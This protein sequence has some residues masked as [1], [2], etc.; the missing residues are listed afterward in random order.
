MLVGMRWCKLLGLNLAFI[1]LLAGVA[2]AAAP[3]DEGYRDMYSRDFASAHTRFAAWMADHPDDPL[4]PASDA[5]AYMFPEFDRLQIIDVQLFGEPDP[6]AGKARPAPDVAVRAHFDQRTQQAE[7]LADA[8]LAKSPKDAPA[9]FVKML[10]YGLRADY[11]EMI[12]RSDLKALKFS[13][14][15]A[16]YSDQT[17]AADPQMYDAHIATGFENYMLSLKP[18]PVRWIIHIMGGQ[19]DKAKGIA[20]L[21][22]TAAKGRY[23]APFA[24]ILLAVAELRDGNKDEAK[25]I[26]TEL[27]TQYPRNPMYAHQLGRIH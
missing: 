15:G 2:C 7:K 5:A 11:A 18:M 3:L 14:K 8:I 19:T 9:L 1:F 25:R 20:E 26:L 24:Q 22:I 17:L 21:K 12:D 23:L 16:D 27:A 10:I 13:E 4:G 6:F